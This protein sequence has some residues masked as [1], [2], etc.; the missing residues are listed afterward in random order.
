MTGRTT[1]YRWNRLAALWLI[2]IVVETR[3]PAYHTDWWLFSWPIRVIEVLAWLVAVVVTVAL[4][5]R[6]RR[7][8][9]GGVAV[10][11]LVPAVLHFTSWALW[12]PESYYRTHRYAFGTVAER[13]LAGEI[14]WVD[15]PGERLPL[16][17]R[18][19]SVNGE[20]E[21]LGLQ[22]GRRM[23][24]LPQARRSYPGVPEGFVFH[25]GRPEPGTRL[26]IDGRHHDFPAE[27]PLGD[28][29][30]YLRP[31]RPGPT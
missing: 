16:P 7:W 5:V 2:V 8:I 10:L 27:R 24:L 22:P 20:I 17:W 18:D 6:R 23:L 15:G 19:L 30:W 21:R 28:G 9:A 3:W 26:N 31:A 1:T 12:H 11:V 29:W 25:E 13:F 14:G 4:L